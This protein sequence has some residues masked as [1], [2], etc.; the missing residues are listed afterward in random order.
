MQIIN[1]IDNL[2]VKCKENIYLALGN[3]DGVHRG[4]QSV[5]KKTVEMAKE[6]N[7]FS[8]ALVFEPHP[9]KII[10]PNS[11]LQIMTNVKMK[12]D[13]LT[14]LGIDYL[15]VEPFTGH[16]AQIP[17]HKFLDIYLKDRVN[18]KGVVTGFDYTFG[19]NA[20]GNTERLIKWGQEN[21]IEIEICPPINIEGNIVSSSIIRNMLLEGKVREAS[22]YLNYY[23]YR[24][25]EVVKGDGRGKKMGFPTANVKISKELIL[26][27]EGVYYTLIEKDEELFCGAGNIGMRP[28]FGSGELTLEVN[29]LNFEGNIYGSEI[30]V[31]FIEK[32]RDEFAFATVDDFKKQLSKDVDIIRKLAQEPLDGLLPKINNYRKISTN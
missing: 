32:I 20:D 9:A 10:N 3:F 12:A 15:I 18:P 26:P 29:I 11:N 4:H 30:T 24:Y 23:Y 19:K 16:I 7:F 14:L 1:G 13:I 22:K 21:N 2:P 27:G 6:K 5:I 25:G 31:Y 8:G 28:T 17:P